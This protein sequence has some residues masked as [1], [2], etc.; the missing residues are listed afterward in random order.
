VGLNP[1]YMLEQIGVGGI[2]MAEALAWL[3]PHVEGLGEPDVNVAYS[4][5]GCGPS[6][7]V[8]DQVG[9]GGSTDDH[10]SG[11][12]GGGEG[13]GEIATKEWLVKQLL[14]YLCLFPP[15][16][17]EGANQ[18]SGVADGQEQEQQEHEGG[19]AKGDQHQQQEEGHVPE[20]QEM[21]SSPGL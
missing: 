4:S 2:H 17:P 11:D 20:D 12:G 5:P 19:L 15:G 13:G 10:G 18:Q 16:T 9:V 7:R 6:S 21:T 3:V 14:P 8:V 1:A